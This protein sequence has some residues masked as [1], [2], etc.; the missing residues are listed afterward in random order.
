M[1]R[2]ISALDG[3]G[4]KPF[5]TIPRTMCLT[6]ASGCSLVGSPR[7]D[8]SSRR[9]QSVL[10]LLEVEVGLTLRGFAEADDADFIFGLRV[11]DRNWHA[12]ALSDPR[13]SSGRFSS[14]LNLT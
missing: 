3:A 7:L 9:P 8:G 1:R 13:T 12:G 5:R 2:D 4:F 14:S 11:N 10:D 6:S